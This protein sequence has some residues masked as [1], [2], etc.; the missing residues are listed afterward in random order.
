MKYIKTFESLYKSDEEETLTD[1]L[2]ELDLDY[3]NTEVFRITDGGNHIFFPLLVKNLIEF[4]NGYRYKT[5]YPNLPPLTEMSEFIFLTIKKVGRDDH[6]IAISFNFKW[7]TISDTVKECL[8]YMDSLGWRNILE[9]M[10][11]G[12]SW[13]HTLETIS[14]IKDKDLEG[15]NI[16][17][18]R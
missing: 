6:N 8:S 1:I 7:D 15:F 18:Y 11:G 16:K 17:F 10:W 2:K 3:F 13:D 9:P 14:E 4:Q 12:I 5:I